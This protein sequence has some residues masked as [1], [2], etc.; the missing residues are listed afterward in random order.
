MFPSRCLPCTMRYRSADLVAVKLTLCWCCGGV[1]AGIFVTM[2][3]AGKAYGGRSK[4]PDNLKQLFRPVAMDVPDNEL[5]AEVRPHVVAYNK[6]PDNNTGTREHGPLKQE[7]FV[8]CRWPFLRVASAAVLWHHSL[9]ACLIDDAWAG[10][11]VLGGLLGCQ[12][13]G[14]QDGVSVPP[15]APAAV[16]TAGAQATSAVVAAV[17]VVAVAT[18]LE[19]PWFSVCLVRCSIHSLRST[20]TGVSVP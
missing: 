17:V 15:V 18:M 6:N 14:Q 20:T 4:L 13:P 2:N 19:E 7:A 11:A 3:P 16:P 5:I 1:R 8:V 9:L 10:H 12:G